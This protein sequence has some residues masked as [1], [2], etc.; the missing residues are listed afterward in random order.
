MDYKYIEQLLERYWECETTAEEEQILRTFFQQ[1]ELPENL[2]CYRDLFAVQAEVRGAHLGEDFDQRMK[3]L[4]EE[5][6]PEVVKAR[7][8]S[9]AHRFRPLYQ[10]AGMVALLVVFGVGAKKH[11]EME[12]A[13]EAERVAAVMEQEGAVE[14]FEI[15]EGLQSASIEYLTDTLS[16]NN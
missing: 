15:D 13:R 10:A 6:A 8:I 5:A 9:L 14:E 12:E 2:R 3:A 1:E 7:K 16:R 4:V 11:F